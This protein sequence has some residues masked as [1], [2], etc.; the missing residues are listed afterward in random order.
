MLAA[1]WGSIESVV[2]DDV[3]WCGLAAHV[4]SIVAQTLDVVKLHEYQKVRFLKNL[5]V[6][7]DIED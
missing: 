1:L 2:L 5:A 3:G 7:Q 6:F 4:P